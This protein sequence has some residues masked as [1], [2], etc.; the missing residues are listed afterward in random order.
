MIRRQLSLSE[1]SRLQ[2]FVRAGGQTTM[3]LPMEQTLDES[4]LNL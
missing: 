2:L 1:R 4:R 3:T